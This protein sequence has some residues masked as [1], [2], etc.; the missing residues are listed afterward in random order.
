MNINIT[1]NRSHSETLHTINIIC[2]PFE[3]KTGTLVTGIPGL[4]IL[5]FVRLFTL[6]YG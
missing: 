2:A 1:I 4:I 5:V 3:H 6:K